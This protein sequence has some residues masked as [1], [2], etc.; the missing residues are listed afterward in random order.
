MEIYPIDLAIHVVNIVVLYILLRLFLFKPVRKFMAAREERINGQMSKADEVKAEAERIKNE[1]SEKLAG[2]KDECE[3]IV[4]QGYKDGAEHAQDI[5]R[6]AEKEAERI[7]EQAKQEAQ[8]Y[9]QRA[10]DSAK[11]E[12]AGIAVDMAGR[13]L[14]F[15]DE[16]KKR[17][18]AGNTRK[19]GRKTGVL[20]LAMESS[21]EDIA[22][23]TA[24]LEAILGTEL[25]LKTEVDDSLIGGYAAY[26]DGKVYDFS[27]ASQ[28][29]NMKKKLS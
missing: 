6:E 29:D 17:V 4:A 20:K 25:E 12:L 26:I 8:E 23:V 7:I 13:I 11:D 2:A 21:P 5:T 19:S 27:Y 22:K 28:L 18:A 9:K 10:M 1:Y 16:I 15:D 24:Q 14:R 3:A